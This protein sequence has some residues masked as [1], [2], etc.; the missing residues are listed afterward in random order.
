M[1]TA[2]INHHYMH[3][4]T[5]STGGPVYS[6]VI[7]FNDSDIIM[8]RNILTGGFIMPLSFSF[9]F[10]IYC[11]DILATQSPLISGKCDGGSNP[12]QS[13]ESQQ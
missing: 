5:T 7:F 3:C 4:S 13:Y 1:A 6:R 10:I 2:E 8:N 11:V 12:E 9:I